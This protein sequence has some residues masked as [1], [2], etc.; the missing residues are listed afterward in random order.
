M[1]S[2]I[3][4][5]QLIGLTGLGLCGF[6]LI[7]MVGNLLI[8]VG[9]KAYNEYSHALISNPLIYLAEAGLLFMFVAHL[10]LASMISIAN[11]CAR[12][13]RYAVLSNGDKGTSWIQRSLWAQGL[14]ILVFT[15]L[16]LITFKY[17]QHYTADYGHGGIR[18]L[19]KLVVEI[20]HQPGYVI[21]YVIALIT[22]LFH[23]SHG[24][25]SSLQTFGIHQPRFQRGIKVA[26]WIYALV[27]GL[28]FIVQPVYVYFLYQG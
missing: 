23:L 5:K 17:G 14:L 18:D 3:G 26:S 10:A 28:G 6:V 1:G 22:L 25:A 12:G 19:H 16:H 27:V 15:V 4:R 11:L 20:F 21:W 7:H 24:L 13:S 2:T 8:L 9:P